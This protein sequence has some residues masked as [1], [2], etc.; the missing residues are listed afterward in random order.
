VANI[1][2]GHNER[3][4]KESK[5]AREGGTEG[6]QRKEEGKKVGRSCIIVWREKGVKEEAKMRLDS[7]EKGNGKHEEE[8]RERLEG[9][10]PEKG[11]KKV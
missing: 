7:K 6:E 9:E 5:K 11:G 2:I 10:E 3:G 4:Y 8:G 1:R